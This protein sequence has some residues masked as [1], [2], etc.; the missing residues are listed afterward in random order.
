MKLTDYLLLGLVAGYCLWLLLRRR[1]KT[2]TGCC[3][4]CRGCG[5]HA[6]E[7]PE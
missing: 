6:K 2:C 7:K 3:A 1:K 5:T 4:G